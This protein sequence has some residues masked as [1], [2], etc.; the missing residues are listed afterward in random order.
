VPDLTQENRDTRRHR[1]GA[2][3]V[4]AIVEPGSHPYTDETRIAARILGLDVERRQ[5]A[6][7]A[8]GHRAERVIVG[9][10]A[11]T[12]GIP[13]RASRRTYV[14]S[15][16]PLAATPDALVL[17]GLGLIEAK[18]TRRGWS[19]L[20]LGCPRDWY[21]QAMAQ[22]AC[23]GRRYVV[24]S[25]LAGSE[26]YLWRIERDD[27]AIARMVS[28]V[29][30]FATTYLDTRTLPP[31]ASPELT[32]ALELPAGT[33]LADA[34]DQAIADTIAW[35]RTAAKVAERE[36]DAARAALARSMVARGL[37]SLQ[38]DGWQAT[39]T[40]QDGKPAVLRV[41]FSGQR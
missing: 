8:L 32:F 24:V 34:T 6:G 7:M 10:A 1:V 41:T 13:V 17:D 2:S 19:E 40:A 37:A 29:Q 3:E 11:D 33:G 22:M 20:S 21:W 16:C 23:T 39:M 27:D 25:A 28:A 9:L 15:L 26:H 12:L 30:L 4:A 36:S 38:G 35:H 14:H 18:L 31:E 5:S